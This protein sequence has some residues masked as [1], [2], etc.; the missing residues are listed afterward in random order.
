M[1]YETPSDVTCKN[2]HLLDS[3][4][5][6]L[7]GCKVFPPI[8]T[9]GLLVR[10]SPESTC[11]HRKTP[12][13]GGLRPQISEPSLST[14]VW[15]ELSVNGL[16]AVSVTILTPQRAEHNRI[17]SFTSHYWFVIYICCQKKKVRDDRSGPTWSR[18]GCGG[19]SENHFALP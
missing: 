18:W 13:N 7:R 2:H 12:G 9:N 8:C 11:V 4:T 14:I 19:G 6:L 10:P 1:R 15:S 16:R 3:Q 17:S 5:R